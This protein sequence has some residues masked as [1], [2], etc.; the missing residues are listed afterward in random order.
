MIINLEDGK[1]P[2]CSSFHLVII[3]SAKI[4]FY[5]AFRTEYIVLEIDQLYAIS[6]SD[7]SMM[8]IILKFKFE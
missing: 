1:G 2:S 6:Y 8:C 7:C 5:G 3:I 4:V